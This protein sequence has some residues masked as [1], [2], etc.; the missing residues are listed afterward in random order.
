MKTR[1]EISIRIDTVLTDR[2]SFL[3][4]KTKILTPYFKQKRERNQLKNFSDC[5]Y[6]PVF[7]SLVVCVPSGEVPLYLF[8]GCSY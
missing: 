4:K 7:C 1:P 5:I 2:I 6:V 8:I 3:Q